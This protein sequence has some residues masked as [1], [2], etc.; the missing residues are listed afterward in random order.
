M[1]D[2]FAEAH[3]HGEHQ[4]E[5]EEIVALMMEIEPHLSGYKRGVIVLALC[6]L[7]AAMLGPAA[8]ETREA[9]LQ[10][11]PGAIRGILREIDRLIAVTTT[12]QQ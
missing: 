12:R 11:M 5:Q 2:N 6:R 3:A 9:M 1:S 7:L 8:P 10:A 4:E